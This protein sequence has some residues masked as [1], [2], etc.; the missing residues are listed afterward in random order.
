MST[1]RTKVNTAASS[2]GGIGGL[3]AYWYMF[4][5]Q[6]VNWD[7]QSIFTSTHLEAFVTGS[8]AAFA[9]AGAIAGWNRDQLSAVSSPGVVTSS[10]AAVFPGDVVKV[11]PVTSDFVFGKTSE[12]HLS[13]ADPDLVEVHRLALQL[14][15]IDFSIID[16]GRTPAEQR[17]NIAKGVSWTMNS[18]HL[19]TPA[20]AID[21]V[22]YVG[23]QADWSV[24]AFRL[25][26]DA[27][28]DAA[29]MLDVKCTHGIDWKGKKLDGAHTELDRDAYPFG[30]DV[31]MVLS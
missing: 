17:A 21:H 12:K 29:R 2:K 5:S 28:K 11:K 13:E 25:T 18:R 3:I 6:V 10:P 9:G 4:A 20:K 26:T 1:I 31:D 30:D 7:I 14:S 23:G 15:P 22:P 27:I 8:I 16:A 24:E 19:E